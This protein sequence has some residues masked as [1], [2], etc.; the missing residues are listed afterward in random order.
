MLM[1]GANIL[2]K[3]RETMGENMKFL[4]KYLLGDEVSKDI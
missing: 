3:Y 2:S 1:A 4:K